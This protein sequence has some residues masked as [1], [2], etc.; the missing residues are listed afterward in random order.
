MGG[1]LGSAYSS[2]LESAVMKYPDLPP[3]NPWHNGGFLLF[4][5]GRTISILGTTI[6]SVVLPILVYR[7]TGSALQTSLLA[8][9]EVVPYLCFGLFAGVVVP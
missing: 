3:K 4:W 6:T 2:R 8:V 7:T 9:F 5:C 1:T